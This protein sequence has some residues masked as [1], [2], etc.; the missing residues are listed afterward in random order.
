MII[1]Y[2][3]EGLQSRTV[4]RCGE[5]ESSLQGWLWEIVFVAK[6]C[7]VAK[8]DDREFEL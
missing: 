3:F 5:Q 8:S 2:P 6:L 4:E 7:Y 1:D